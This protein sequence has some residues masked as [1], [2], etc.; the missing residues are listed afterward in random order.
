MKKNNFA[1]IETILNVA[2]KGG[3]YILVDYE[4]R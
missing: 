1:T 4:K 3:M 2:K